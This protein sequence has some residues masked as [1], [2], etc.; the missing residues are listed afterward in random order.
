MK[1]LFTTEKYMMK[2]CEK[3]LKVMTLRNIIQT[4]LI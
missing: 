3:A 2:Y 4:L 1:V